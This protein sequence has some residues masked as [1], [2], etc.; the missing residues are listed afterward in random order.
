M[1]F[2]KRDFELFLT[3]TAWAY[4]I[5]SEIE[6]DGQ[7]YRITRQIRQSPTLLVNGGWAE[8][9]EIRGVKLKAVT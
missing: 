6:R 7:K 5:G 1:I 8:C 3:H 4:P 2:R 9:Y